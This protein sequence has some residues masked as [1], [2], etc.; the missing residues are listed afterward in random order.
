MKFL[1]VEHKFLVPE[2]FSLTDF[3]AACRLLHPVREKTVSV[4]DT[5]YVPQWDAGFIFRHRQDEELHELTVKTRGGDPEVRTEVNVGLGGAAD[6][7]EVVAAFMQT[8]GTSDPLGIQKTLRVFDFPDCEVVHYTA[9]HAGR[10]VHCV[11]FEA[12]HQKDLESAHSV[13]QRYEKALGF[14]SHERSS[15]SLFDLLVPLQSQVKA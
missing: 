5:Y 9:S 6:A 14:D 8:V 10:F 1:E 7:A 13:L 11:E 12:K 4:Q 3:K 2:D 15:V